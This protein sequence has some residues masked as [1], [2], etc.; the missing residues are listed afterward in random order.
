MRREKRVNGMA[1][2]DKVRR[3][4]II[5]RVRAAGERAC[6]EAEARRTEGKVRPRFPDEIGGPA[7]P[8]PTRYG[9]WERKGIASDF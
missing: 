1:G 8:E 4:T 3:V 9:D 6:A 2:T 7:A 5:E